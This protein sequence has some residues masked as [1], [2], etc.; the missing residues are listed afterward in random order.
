MLLFYGNG[1]NTAAS[2][3]PR[4]SVFLE[5]RGDGGGL[6]L[7]R[8]LRW[9]QLFMI[10]TLCFIDAMDNPHLVYDDGNND[11]DHRANVQCFSFTAMGRTPQLLLSPTRKESAVIFLFVLPAVMHERIVCSH[12]ATRGCCFRAC[13]SRRDVAVR[14]RGRSEV[15][16]SR[17]SRESQEKERGDEMRTITRC[18]IYRREIPTQAQQHVEDDPLDLAEGFQLSQT[19]YKA[20]KT[21]GHG[22]LRHALHFGSWMDKE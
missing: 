3:V 8:C 20:V 2:S 18:M 11:H 13:A 9:L 21:V 7:L 17:A 10:D 15:G 16:E 12:A 19:W 5:V 1:K 4:V 14:N 22:H 6:N